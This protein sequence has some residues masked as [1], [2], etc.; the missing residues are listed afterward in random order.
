M[1]PS[2]VRSLNVAGE[3]SSA[4][5]ALANVSTIAD[6][7]NVVPHSWRAS[8][9]NHLTTTYRI[10]T[11]LCNVQNTIAQYDKH[12]A[13]GSFPASIKNAIKDPKIQFSKEYLGSETGALANGH[14][15]SVVHTARK[16]LLEEAQKR[17]KEELA[18]LQRLTTFDKDVWTKLVLEV[19]QRTATV[20]GATLSTVNQNG[21]IMLNWNGKVADDT[22]ADCLYLWN[23]GSAFHYKAVS[24]ARAIADRSLVEK[25]KTLSLKKDADVAMRDADAES[26]TRD[27]VRDEMQTQLRLLEKKLVQSLGTST[28]KRQIDPNADYDNRKSKKV[29]PSKQQEKEGRLEPLSRHERACQWQRQEERPTSLTVSSFLQQCSKDFRPWDPDTYPIVYNSLTAHSRMT[30]NV[31]FTRTW[32][33]DS[34]RAASPGVFKHPDVVLPEDIEYMLAVNHKFIFHQAP[35]KHD[36]EKAKDSFR[37]RVRNAYFFH[38]K[39]NKEFIPKFHVAN[40]SWNPPL[41]SSA[42]EQGINAAMETIDSQVAQALTSIAVSST[43]KGFSSWQKVQNFVINKELIIKL[44]DKNLGLAVL[45]VKWYDTQCL[46][47]LADTNTYRPVFHDPSVAIYDTLISQVAN[48][49]LPPAMEKYILRKTKRETPQ[50]HAIPKVHKTPW[51]VRPIVPSHSWVTTTTSEIIDHLC[52]PLLEHFPWVVNSSKEVIN[53]IEKV[54][55][56]GTEPIWILTGDVTAFYTNIPPKPC[57]KIIGKVW[58]VFCKESSIP[59]STIKKMVRFVMDNN[60]LEYKGQRFH[61]MNGLAMGTSCAPVIA[62]LYAAWFE[63]KAR[64]VYQDGVLLYVRYIDDILC[65]FQGSRNEAKVFCANLKI[66]PLHIGWAP[67]LE[68]NEF[69]DIELLRMPNISPRIVH[70]R[71]FRKPMNRHLYIPWSSAHPSH[72]KKGFVKAELIRFA[73]ICSTHEYFADARREFYGNLRRRGYPAQTLNEWFKQVT[74]DSRPVLLLFRKKEE[75]KA[76]LMLSGHYNPVWDYVDV[77]KVITE[78]RRFWI[79]EE[80]PDVLQE[81]LIRSLGRTKSLFDLMSAWN[82]TVLLSASTDA[83]IT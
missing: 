56:L 15:Q 23:K 72:V 80:L 81:P 4:G 40:T 68:R 16:S 77:N 38:G 62:N 60:Y 64:I 54:R 5:S 20:F 82:K 33:I 49:R 73:I 24:L 9:G 28:G 1:A 69:L 34:L 51:T 48:W 7:V 36:V 32:E 2:S 78:A 25:T 45:P 3:P 47:M 21:A 18:A 57:S 26:S 66:G 44:T 13:E 30:I 11:K 53:Q 46:K 8:I 63:R 12:H 70:T 74:Y 42:I 83:E 50:F 43:A 31:A 79:K 52:Q 58:E 65:I 37:R 10:A 61:Q 22:K 71:L 35:H 67:S 76:P 55:T 27:V 29:R 17:K 39:S 19:G 14:L 41:A 59:P 75:D 6:L